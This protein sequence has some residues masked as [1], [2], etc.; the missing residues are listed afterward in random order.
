MHNARIYH[1]LTMLADGTVLAIGGS[2]DQRPEHRHDRRSA[3]RNLESRDRNVD[4]GGADRGG[5]QLPLDRDPDAERDGAGRPAAGTRTGSAIPA[6][7]PPRSTRP[8]TCPT[9]R[10][11]RSP[12]RPPPRHTTRASRVSTP[13][14]L[15]DRRR[16]PRLA[17]RGHPPGRHGPAL[18]AAVV[19]GRIRLAHGA[20][21]G[22]LGA[23]PVRQLHAVHR[24]QKGRAVGV[25]AAQPQRGAPSAR[26]RPPGVTAT[27]SG[28]Q[29][30]GDLDRAGPGTSPITSY[31]V[32][33][34]IGTAAQPPTTING[35]PPATSATITGLTNGITYTFKVTATNA[36]GTGPASA[37]SNPVTPS[38]PHRAGCADRR[39]RDPGQR[40]RDRELDRAR[41]QRQ[42]D[43]Q[44]HDHAVHRHHRADRRP[45][46]RAL[47]PRRARR[48]RA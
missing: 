31:T 2:V 18:R 6:S 11:R 48:S 45:R 22:Q 43:H 20:D 21:A 17:R 10:A 3:D 8:P 33:P 12:R 35:S 40:Q 25:R 24:Q 46:S 19:H 32:T 38:A 29:R 26:R 1:T 7:S 44:L 23:R 4:H 14:A 42:P 36:V 27:A 16:Q 34:Y 5:P 13:D 9:G 28:R 39:Q 41:V 47:R 15:V 30:D 37:A